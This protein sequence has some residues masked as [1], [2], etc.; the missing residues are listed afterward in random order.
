[1]DDQEQDAISW[2]PRGTCPVCGSEEVFHDMLGMPTPEVFYSAPPWVSFGCTPTYRDR[3][4]GACGHEWC[5]PE[6]DAPED[7]DPESDDPG[8]EEC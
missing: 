6:R 8:S 4:C 1:M 2:P 5:L 7:D 3:H